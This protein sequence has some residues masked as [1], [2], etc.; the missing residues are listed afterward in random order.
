MCHIDIELNDYIGKIKD[1]FAEDD[2]V[3]ILLDYISTGVDTPIQFQLRDSLILEAYN[4]INKKSL[5]I[6]IKPINNEY[7][8]LFQEIY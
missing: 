2:I 3:E 1:I 7:T 8:Y 5:I 4:D 6:D